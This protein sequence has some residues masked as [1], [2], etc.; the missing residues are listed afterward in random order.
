MNTGN[1]LLYLLISALLGFMAVSGLLGQQNLLRLE[2]SV[3]PTQDIFA[4]NPAVVEVELHNLR[5]RLPAFLIR[6]EMAEGDVLFPLLAAGQRQR[7]TLSLTLSERGYQTLPPIRIA[8]CFPINF[9]V[10]SRSQQH[11]RQILVF[12]RPVVAGLPSA[13]GDGQ[14][15]R[16]DD[17]QQ[18]GIDGELR[19]IDSYRAADPMKSIHWKLSARHDDYKV[20]RQQR[21]GAPSLLLDLDDFVGPLEERLG[22]CTYLINQ[23][24]RQQ[25]AVGLRLGEQ[26]FP[27]S[28][29]AVHRHKLLTELALYGRR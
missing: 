1:N 29:G 8:S 14:H 3:F 2:V 25:R 22:C 13:T 21:L 5:R 9:F 23:M 12:P 28:H 18:P 19:S 16:R 11:D 10:R 7:H 27:P 17:L 24:N 26:L 6:V 4:G 20:K 15:A